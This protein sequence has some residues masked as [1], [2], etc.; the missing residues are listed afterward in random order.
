MKEIDS[1]IT[2]LM[3]KQQQHY[4]E[5]RNKVVKLLML[6]K[7]YLERRINMAQRK[8]PE[9]YKT[10][11]WQWNYRSIGLTKEHIKRLNN[12]INILESLNEHTDAKYLKE[13]KDKLLEDT[14]EPQIVKINTDAFIEKAC[15]WLKEYGGGYWMDDY[16]LPTDELVNDFRNAMKGE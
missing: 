5:R 16:D 8:L 7:I 14:P 1:L 12:A 9:K 2:Y 3:L 10:C 6:T 13:I 4:L 11:D 15:E